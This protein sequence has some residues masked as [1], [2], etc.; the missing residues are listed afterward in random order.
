[1]SKQLDVFPV[2]ETERLILRKIEKEDAQD[3]FKYL[4]DKEVMKYYG[5]E[6]FQTVDEAVRTISRYESVFKE[7]S[8]IRWGITLKGANQV[9]GSCF[10]YDMASEHYR[11]DLGYVLNK[12]YWGQGIA[13][14]A[15]KAAIKYGFENLN[16]NRIQ[17][18]I[19]PPNLASQKLAER[20]GFLR[21]GL[22]RDYE[23]FSGKFDDLYMYSFLKSDLNTE[24]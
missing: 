3:I 19:E 2:L 13:Q 4:S 9:I 14:E 10:F 20:L 11:T 16:I 24:V 6:P 12:D 18:V 21:E 17:S 23:Y 22:L 8:G 5:T 1:M 15:V 7:K